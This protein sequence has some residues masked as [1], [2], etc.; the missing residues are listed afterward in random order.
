MMWSRSLSN[1][2]E[3]DNTFELNNKFCKRKGGLKVDI[4]CN[5]LRHT[6]TDSSKEM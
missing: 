5:V 2:Y 1:T 3:A 6:M 4:S